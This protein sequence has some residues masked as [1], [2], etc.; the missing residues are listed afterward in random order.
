MAKAK[1]I[2]LL[3]LYFFCYTIPQ[4][5]PN[6]Y[7]TY[8]RV[9]VHLLFLSILNVFTFLILV[10]SGDLIKLTSIFKNKI[11]FYSYSI[12]ILIS[13]LS[14]FVADNLVEGLVTLTSYLI[15]FISFIL[16]VCIAQRIKKILLKTFLIFTLLAVFM[17]SGWINYLIYDSVI[18]NGNFLSRNNDFSGFT[19]NINISS[20]SLALK[21]PIL[22]YIIF[23][24]EN[25]YMRGISLVFIF[26]SFLS[27]LLLFSRAAIIALIFIMISLSLL[28]IINKTRN[29]IKN[30]IYVICF[31]FL[32]FI[33]YGLIN[34]K[35]PSD[36]IVDRFS[37]VI[38]NPG[39]DGSVN[40]R[41]N[42][43]STAVN[44]IFRTPLTGIGVGNWKINS[45]DYSRDIIAEYRVPYFVH[46]DFLQITAEIGIIG[47]LAFIY[48][49]FYPFFVSLKK[50][51][52]E[53]DFNLYF[54]IY[55]IMGVYIIDSLLNFP[56]GRVITVIFLLF[57]IMLFYILT[58]NFEDEK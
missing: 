47:G 1:T 57:T 49:I 41:L 14:L 5:I 51:F 55:L 20:F 48:F 11:H 26:S 40:E 34:D 22:L 38:T 18:T 23:K 33:S 9:T 45:V 39:A 4:Y 43:Y 6:L 30:Y 25:K 10:K 36:I 2:S 53:K 44:S 52:Y 19:G 32:S 56:M 17:E 16:I 58:Q 54:M 15:Y 28:L 12:F 35:N 42:F 46:N 13:C 7:Y 29:M 24:S 31:I 21:V 37:N 50:S 3:G 8:D 27:I